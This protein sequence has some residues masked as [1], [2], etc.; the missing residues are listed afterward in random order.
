[1]SR[2]GKH[3]RPTIFR[4]VRSTLGGSNRKKPDSYL[5][6][7]NLTRQTLLGSVI[8][9]AD[10][11]AARR[12]GL[13]GRNCLEPG[14]GLWILPCESI[15]TFGMRFPI[16][17]VYLDRQNNIKKI[18]SN[19]RP[20]RLSACLSALGVGTPLRD[21]S[22]LANPAWRYSRLLSCCANRRLN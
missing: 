13:L 6:I 3:D 7:S 12:K 22:R 21:D 19:V 8:K 11:G 17:L 1:M 15:H 14:E 2:R 10:Q 18:R 16:D 4:R 20:W 5:R 9:V